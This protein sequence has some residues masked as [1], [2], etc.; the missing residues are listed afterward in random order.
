MKAKEKRIEFLHSLA[1]KYAH[2]NNMSKQ[3]AILAILSHEEI[4]E[5]YSHIRF[6][7]QGQ[8]QPQLSEVWIRDIEGRKIILT[9]SE[10]IENHLLNRNKNHLRQASDTLFADGPLGETIQGDGSG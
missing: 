6:K 1:E 3:K 7:L 9:E 10:D 4:R 5:M 8:R 2:E